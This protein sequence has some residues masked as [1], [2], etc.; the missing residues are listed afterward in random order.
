MIQ[1]GK[2]AENIKHIGDKKNGKIIIKTIVSLLLVIIAMGISLYSSP[3]QYNSNEDNGRLQVQLTRKLVQV[4]DVWVKVKIVSG[5]ISILETI[6]VEGS[7]PVIGGLAV[8]AEPLGWT[9]VVDNT[10][11]HISNI[12]LWAMGAITIEK[13]LLAISVWVSLKIIVPVCAILAVIALWNNKFSGHLKKMIAGLMLIFLGIC[14][15]I[16]LSL[17]LSNVIETSVLSNQINETVNEI[18]GKTNEAEKIGDDVNKSSFIDQLKRLGS[19]ITNFFKNIKSI[20]DSFIDNMIN[21]IMC[22][23]VTNL[24]IP[25]GTVL[26]LKYLIGVILKL[27]GF[28][29]KT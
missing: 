13:L 3:F 29:E 22:F 7:I 17:E 16:P 23:I 28:Y 9:D 19:G 8:S 27:I 24:I 6:Q 25:I 10:L 20:F 2:G 18:E 14:S 1:I 26:G 11:D 4:A 21:Y 12:C 5:V 15:A